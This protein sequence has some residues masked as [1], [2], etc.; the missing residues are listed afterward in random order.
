[1]LHEI[2]EPGNEATKYVYLT[3][4]YHNCY[5]KVYVH[6][7]FGDLCKNSFYTDPPSCVL[8]VVRCTETF[9][10]VLDLLFSY[11]PPHRIIHYDVDLYT[12]VSEEVNFQTL[13]IINIILAH[14]TILCIMYDQMHN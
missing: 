2:G 13:E 12:R 1:M 7:M 4:C 14:H 8:L 9:E 10:S 5:T 11:T 6:C 3:N